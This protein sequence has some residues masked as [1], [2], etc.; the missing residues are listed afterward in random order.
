MTNIRPKDTAKFFATNEVTTIGY[1]IG[2]L[3]IDS[4]SNESFLKE[5]IAPAKGK[6]PERHQYY[7]KIGPRG[8]FYNPYGADSDLNRISH[9]RGDTDW[10]YIKTTMSAFQH[11]MDFMKTSNQK[12]YHFAEREHL[13]V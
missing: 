1:T 8:L 4:N 11:Y 7:I 13:N 3:K 12:H 5:T 9:K 10:R 2:G 6:N